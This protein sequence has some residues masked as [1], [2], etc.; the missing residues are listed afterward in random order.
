MACRRCPLP[1]SPASVRDRLP[2]AP[3]QVRTCATCAH[4]TTPPGDGAGTGAPAR[5]P[6][7][8]VPLLRGAARSSLL[9]W[10][11]AARPCVVVWVCGFVRFL[12]LRRRLAA[13]SSVDRSAPAATTATRA[14]RLRA[15]AGVI[16]ATLRGAI[17]PP[18][19]TSSRAVLPAGAT[20][21]GSGCRA[22]RLLS[23]ANW[24]VVLPGAVQ[25][26]GADRW[27]SMTERCSGEPWPGSGG[28]RTG[29]DAGA[30]AIRA[31]S[32]V[33]EK[34]QWITTAWGPW[35]GE[36]LSEDCW[37]INAERRHRART[38]RQ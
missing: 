6:R 1:A 18:V 7:T 14:T 3:G 26:C 30:V 32:Q 38:D 15:R 37:I 4:I 22:L 36:R 21:T 13:A 33:P 31:L 17:G 24:R 35:G 16:I 12:R 27:V 9:Q 2:A 19:R 20:C 10:A 11:P 34:R 28:C 8:T 29:P 25:W 23:L 5:T